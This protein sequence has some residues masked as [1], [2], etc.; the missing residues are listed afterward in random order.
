MKRCPQCDFIYEDEQR[1]CDFDGSELAAYDTAA[2]PPPEIAAPPPQAVPPVKSRRRGFILIPVAGVILAA[3][4]YFV[5]Y[6]LPHQAAPKD[7]SQSP[8]KL[9]P[10]PQP[11]SHSVLVPIP[12]ADTPAPAPTPS[13]REVK[14]V[15]RA[16]P[17]VRR[18]S[19]NDHP[20]S[21][22]QEVKPE[23]ARPQKESKLGSIMKKTGRLLKKPFKF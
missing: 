3:A 18:P 17:T 7:T 16:L 4:L 2:L 15:R 19:V 20:P 1:V 22:R 13:V 8:V 14:A 10:T 9:T 5:Y 21:P 23:G 11:E 6:S 12:A